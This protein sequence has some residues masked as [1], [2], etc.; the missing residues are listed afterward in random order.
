[1]A[2]H[3]ASIQNKG[4]G[5][6]SL[7]ELMMVIAI[8][9]TLAAIAVPNYIAY[10]D[11]AQMTKAISDIQ[12]IERQ[13]DL[14]VLDND[15]L[16]ASL[17]EIGLDGMLDPY[18]NPYEYQP[19]AGTPKGKLRKDRFMVPVNSDYDLYSKGQDGRSVSPFTAKHSRDDIVRANDGAYVGL[20]ADF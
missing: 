12:F 3:N 9:G 7:I 18:G 17:A 14:F 4:P 11:K 16:P 15:R 8:I 10:R 1:M 13:I 2:K 19:V 6:F 5:G 20:A